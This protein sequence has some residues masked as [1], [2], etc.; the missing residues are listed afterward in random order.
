MPMWSPSTRFNHQESGPPTDNRFQHHQKGEESYLY[1]INS[2]KA[3]P[4]QLILNKTDL[5]T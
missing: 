4:E 3:K 5:S 2:N 1:T